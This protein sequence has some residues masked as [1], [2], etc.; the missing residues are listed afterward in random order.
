[1]QELMKRGGRRMATKE[2]AR[3]LGCAIH[4]ITNHA[5]RLFPGKLRNGVKT[6]FDE[7]E[8]TLIL[9]AMKQSNG[10]QHDL[11]SSLQG[12]KT[13]LTPALRLEM[14][15][16]QIDEIK[17]AEIARLKQEQEVLQIR[18]SEAEE[19]YSVKRV[20][21]ETGKE[22]PWKPLKEYSVQHGYFVEKTF[23]KNYGE[24]NAY[25]VDVWNK[26]YGVEL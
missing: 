12:T 24:V 14:L 18:L 8:V 13:E 6:Y 23:D 16:R 19:W 10:N 21:I 20:L 2:V 22:Y 9:E 11:A 17:T 7:K 25:H 1:M 4:T 26:V 15:Y 3:Q 5:N